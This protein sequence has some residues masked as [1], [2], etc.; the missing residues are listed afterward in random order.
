MKKS[1]WDISYELEKMCEKKF[2]NKFDH[3][4][5]IFD[6]SKIEKNMFFNVMHLLL[7]MDNVDGD[8]AMDFI[9]KHLDLFDV[10]MNDIPDY[11]DIFEEF[12]KIVNI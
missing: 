12:S 2:N 9:D 1:I 5:T 4:N 10:N 6:R 7:H 3:T 8:Q 11:E